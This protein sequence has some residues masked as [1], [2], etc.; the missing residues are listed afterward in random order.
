M[1][2]REK[3]EWF[4]EQGRVAVYTGIERGPGGPYALRGSCG[5][6]G[7]L[8]TNNNKTNKQHEERREY[9]KVTGGGGGVHQ[10]QS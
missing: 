1:G 6:V 3:Y 10:Q 5:K 8:R 9:H 7:V 2:G 4:A